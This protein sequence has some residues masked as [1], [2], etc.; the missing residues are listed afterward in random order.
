MGLKIK[1]QKNFKIVDHR[2]KP[3]KD[4]LGFYFC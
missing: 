4:Q 3:K 2:D 1:K